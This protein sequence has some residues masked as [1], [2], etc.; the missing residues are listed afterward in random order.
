MEDYRKAYWKEEP[1]QVGEFITPQGGD[2]KKF[3][4]KWNKKLQQ[5]WQTQ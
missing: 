2:F 1:I 4:N 5:V 3:S